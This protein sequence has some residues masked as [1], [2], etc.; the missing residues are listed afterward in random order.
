MN[1]QTAASVCGSYENTGLLLVTHKVARLRPAR[2]AV[3]TT[4]MASRARC[5]FGE[6]SHIHFWL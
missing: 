2:N 3:T 6:T 4:M 5:V 1:L